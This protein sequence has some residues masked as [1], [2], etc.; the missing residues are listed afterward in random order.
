MMA[1]TTALAS[2]SLFVFVLRRGNTFPRLDSRDHWTGLRQCWRIGCNR[3][4]GG[5][6]IGRPRY[7]QDLSHN[8]ADL[9]EIQ[10][11]EA[12]HPIRGIEIPRILRQADEIADRGISGPGPAQRRKRQLRRYAGREESLDIRTDPNR[13]DRRK[14]RRWRGL[15]GRRGSWLCALGRA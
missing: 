6:R 1:A 4:G 2:F 11:A 3:G 12:R 9:L 10:R 8:S 14:R 13:F 7:V 15:D 5:G